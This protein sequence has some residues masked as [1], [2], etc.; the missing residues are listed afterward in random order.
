MNASVTAYLPLV[1]D[2]KRINVKVRWGLIVNDML[3][4]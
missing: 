3:I 1:I 2:D 4:K